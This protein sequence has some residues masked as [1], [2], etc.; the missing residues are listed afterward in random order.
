V[1]VPSVLVFIVQARGKTEINVQGNGREC[2]FHT[3]SLRSADGRGGRLDMSCG[4]ADG[5]QIPFGFAQGRLSAAF[6]GLGMTRRF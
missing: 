6:G 3:A 1:H 2:P 5:Q 4:A